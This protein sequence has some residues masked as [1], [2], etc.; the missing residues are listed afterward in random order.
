[1]WRFPS[2]RRC[3]CPAMS[4]DSLESTCA[5]RYWR[6][7]WILIWGFCGILSLGHAVFFALGGY[8]MGMHLMRQIGTRGV[9][10]H[11]VLPDFMV[12]LNW[13][14]LP[15]FWYGFDRFWFALVMVVLVPATLAFV[16]GW[17]AFAPGSPACI[18]PSC[19]RRSATHCCSPS[20]ATTW[21]S[22]ATMASRTSRISWASTCR[23]IVR[24]RHCWWRQLQ[25]WR[26]ATAHAG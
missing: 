12:F 21:V 4:S 18:S 9:Y 6:P 3:I 26:L 11:P 19:R 17:L 15:W 2:P 24:V 22:A 25:H 13:D 20:S 5:T 8:A 23:V 1:M 7:P 10:G 14:A 16:F